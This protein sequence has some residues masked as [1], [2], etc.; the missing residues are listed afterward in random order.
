MFVG[1]CW[2]QTEKWKQLD[3]EFNDIGVKIIYSPYTEGTSSK[4]IN[5]KLNE[6]RKRLNNDN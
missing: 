5:Q 1:D 2:Y 3:K 6:K 4:L